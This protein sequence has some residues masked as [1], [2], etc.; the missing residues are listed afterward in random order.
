MSRAAPVNQASLLGLANCYLLLYEAGL[1]GNRYRNSAR[2]YFGQCD[3][4][5][6]KKPLAK[7]KCY[8]PN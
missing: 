1:P 8:S 7:A 5:L 4:C 2:D 6:R 3:Y